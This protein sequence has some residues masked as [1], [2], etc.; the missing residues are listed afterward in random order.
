MDIEDNKIKPIGEMLQDKIH[1]L[2][3]ENFK[4]QARTDR[5]TV[6]IEKADTV[7]D[8]MAEEISEWLGTCP[9]DKY[10]WQEIDCDKV[11]EDDM[12]ECWKQYFYK[13]A[14]DK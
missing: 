7:I 1:R 9:L 3:K 8:L 13:K 5:L 11:C 2:K 6:E 14:E 12:K 4:L 10:D